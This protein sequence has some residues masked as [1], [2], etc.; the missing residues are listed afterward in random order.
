MLR[1]QGVGAAHLRASRRG[2]ALPMV[3]LVLAAL[4]LLATLALADA[5]QA[6]QIGR[7]HV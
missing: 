7:A 4:G 2:I 3:L 5:M 6:M 1:S